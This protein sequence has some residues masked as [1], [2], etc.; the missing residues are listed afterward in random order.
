MSE[1]LSQDEIDQLLTAINAGDEPNYEEF[2]PAKDC[3]RIKIYDF[4]RPE[5]YKDTIAIY[6]ARVSEEKINVEILSVVEN[7]ITNMLERYTNT[8]NIIRKNITLPF[9]E[10]AQ[11]SMQI[12]NLAKDGTNG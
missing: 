11:I 6:L 7:Y 12:S 3:R 5:S 2:K 10:D 9:S 4:K 1:V 8:D